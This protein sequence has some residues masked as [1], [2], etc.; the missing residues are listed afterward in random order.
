MSNISINFEDTPTT[1]E[2]D[3]FSFKGSKR[4]ID[5][6]DFQNLVSQVE[7]VSDISNLSPRR[8]AENIVAGEYSFDVITQYPG[9]SGPAYENLEQKFVKVFEKIASHPDSRDMLED[10]LIG[11]TSRPDEISI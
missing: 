3:P 8:L 4:D 9:K 7:K 5:A 1:Q 11:I 2:S 6:T 10:L